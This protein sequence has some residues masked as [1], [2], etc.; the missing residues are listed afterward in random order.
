MRLECILTLSGY[1]FRMPDSEKEDW[2]LGLSWNSK[3][4]NIQGFLHGV[5]GNEKD[6]LV[7]INIAYPSIFVL[8]LL[9]TLSFENFGKKAEDTVLLMQ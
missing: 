2:T 5:R 7:W 9:S 8:T 1:V 6:I 3:L 4:G